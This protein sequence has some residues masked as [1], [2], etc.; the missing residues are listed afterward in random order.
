MLGLDELRD[1]VNYGGEF[2]DLLHTASS[3]PG[4]K[5]TN[6]SP[7]TRSLAKDLVDGLLVGTSAHRE[8]AFA[9]R[10]RDTYYA[11]RHALHDALGAN[12]SLLWNDNL[13]P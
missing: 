9:G 7:D 8:H 12:T 13:K 5:L 10:D 6:L 11:E 3:T 1:I 2:L 4:A